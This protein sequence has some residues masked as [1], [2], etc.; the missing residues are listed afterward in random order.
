MVINQ[1]FNLLKKS[2]YLVFKNDYFFS[3]QKKKKKENIKLSLIEVSYS[4][5]V[6]LFDWLL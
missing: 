5:I 6:K 2:L 3:D 1:E 4:T